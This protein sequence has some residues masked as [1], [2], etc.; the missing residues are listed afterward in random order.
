MSTTSTPTIVLVH[1]AFAD[2]GSWAPTTALLIEA[3]TEVTAIA[4]PLR[5]LHCD[6]AY[7]ASVIN[8]IP[9]PVLAVGHAYGGSVITHACAATPSVVGLVYVAAFAPD[10]GERLID[11]VGSSH[12]SV[13]TAALVRTEYPTGGG[14]ATA[15]EVVI[16]PERFHAVFAA[17]LPPFQSDVFGH[18]QRPVAVQSFTEETGTPAWRTLPVWAAVPTADA[19]AGSDLVL[20][21]AQR[22]GAT[23]TEIDGSHAISISQP[24]AVAEVILSAHR[25][26]S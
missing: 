6:A 15:A 18:S 7:V 13:L 20:S 5:G 17:D 24:E 16:D 9:G 25:A 4:N 2:A 22:A 19:A 1:G 10:E 12:D 26:V 3:G 23:I 11:A 8:Q 14:D 21:M